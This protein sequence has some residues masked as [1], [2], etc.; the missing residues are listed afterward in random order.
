VGNLI[1]QHEG[2]TVERIWPKGTKWEVFDPNEDNDNI[3]ETTVTGILN[4]G[5]ERHS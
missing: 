5:K 3:V 2:G 4:T 1:Y